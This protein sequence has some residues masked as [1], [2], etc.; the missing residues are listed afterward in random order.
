MKSPLN[1]SSVQLLLVLSAVITANS[2]LIG[3]AQAKRLTFQTPAYEKMIDGSGPKTNDVAGQETAAPTAAA[4]V[5][6]APLSLNGP[7][8]TTTAISSNGYLKSTVAMTGFAPKGPIDPASKS[9]FLPSKSIGDRLGVGEKS[10]LQEARNTGI[11]PLP[12]LQSEEE[13]QQKLDT[14]VSAEKTQ[15][16]DLWESALTR[17]PDIQFVVQKMMPT[18]NPGH[19]SAIMMRM[20]SGAIFGAMG[21]VGMMAPGNYGMYAASNLGGSMLNSLL[22]GQENK[23]A[24]NARLS[25]TE[26][27]MLYTIVRNTADKLVENYR[28]YKKSLVS[29]NKATSD[30][31]ELQNMVSEARA[32]QD[33]AKQVEMEYTLRKGQ[34]EIDELSADVNRYRQCLVDLAGGEAVAKLDKQLDTETCKLD[35]QTPVVN[36]SNNMQA[37]QTAAAPG[38]S[39]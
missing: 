14:I 37:P 13:A 28:S 35:Q 38:A 2:C 18:S 33:A 3:P 31:Q 39:S 15:M 1:K 5:N 36:P 20:L 25:Q 8:E 12:L 21:T 30:L 9:I 4:P 10:I 11:M 22:V 23:N 16:A 32:N 7:V 34:R 24:K 27:I 17:S 19:G 6:L 26:G 29:L